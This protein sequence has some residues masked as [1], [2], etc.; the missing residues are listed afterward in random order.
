[1]KTLAK[2]AIRYAEDHG[3]TYERQNS[4]G[5]L[6]YRSSAGH[7]IG[8]NPSCDER[9]YQR[10]V[11]DVDRACGIGADLSRKRH[12]DEIKARQDRQ[13]ALLKAEKARHQARLDD[14]ARQKAA[15]LLA[16]AGSRLTLREVKAIEQLIEAEQRQHRD[17]VRQMTTRAGAA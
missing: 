15:L 5:L 17:T 16:G 4:K 10:V 12:P 3:Y 9:A 6:Y 2:K 14:L 7:E 8:I 11:H 13:R 1:V